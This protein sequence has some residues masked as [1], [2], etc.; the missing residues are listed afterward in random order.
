VYSQ[1][2]QAALTRHVF[3]KVPLL[4]TTPQVP[5]DDVV[6]GAGIDAS[7]RLLA[8][9]RERCSHADLRVADMHALP[10]AEA[11]F[12]VV[13]RFPGIWGTTPGAV[14]EVHSVLTP[15]WPRRVDGLGH[16]NRSPGAWA[17][18]SRSRW[19]LYRT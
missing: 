16:I 4:P 5:D 7:P 12:D 17:R 14:A 2:L 9:A 8:V 19:P 13:T 18:W 6:I 3:P 1:R 10:W 15:R 11:S